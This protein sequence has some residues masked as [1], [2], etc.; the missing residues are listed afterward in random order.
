M[1]RWTFSDVSALIMMSVSAVIAI[2]HLIVTDSCA[3]LF[4]WLL[5]QLIVFPLLTIS[6]KM[7]S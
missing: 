2:G 7:K 3:W 4:A 1:S 6:E 5:V